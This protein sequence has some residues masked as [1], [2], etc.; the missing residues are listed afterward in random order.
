MQPRKTR[1]LPPFPSSLPSPAAAK[2]TTEYDFRTITPAFGAGVEGRIPDDYT[3][4][5]GTTVRGHLRFWWRATRGRQFNNAQQLRAAE[6]A[7]WGDTK[8]RS[9]IA[10]E[11]FDIKTKRSTAD[12]LI[13]ENSDLTYAL[14]PF[15][16]MG[17]ESAA[18]YWSSLSFGLRL[19][20]PE[21]LSKDAEAAL[22]AWSNFGG[23][24]ARTRRGC[25]A[26]YCQQF[27]P[28]V[29]ANI[30]AWFRNQPDYL[31]RS[32]NDPPDWATLFRA[33]L[34][35]AVKPNDPLS[36]WLAGLRLLQEF[37]QLPPIG[38]SG[39]AGQATTYSRSYWPEADS[40]RAITGQGIPGHMTPQ[41]TTDAFPRAEFGLP[42][43]ITFRSRAKSPLD[44]INNCTLLPEDKESNRLASPLILRPLAFGDGK[45]AV[46]A[47]HL[48][49]RPTLAGVRV[50]F[51]EKRLG[52]KSLGPA[53][54]ARPDLAKY[55]RS[56]LQG[57]A[58]GSAVDAFLAFADKRGFRS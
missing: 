24:G 29:A 7:I 23:I 49:S 57:S 10:V 58:S 27:A 3:P 41:T 2:L 55:P 30:S 22:W 45:Q 14:F 20:C 34:V 15:N 18:P 31:I 39:T 9:P 47:I 26:L 25:G 51:K 40:L 1:T 36:A 11:V 28:P 37:R 52:E 44:E 48:V 6:S 13:G 12:V 53:S 43:Q 5:R 21:N 16:E 35:K 46:S 32:G 17:R 56:P 33:P 42:I 8:T 54:V 50:V 19:T 4:V 38:R